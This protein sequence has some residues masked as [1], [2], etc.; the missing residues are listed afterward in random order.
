MKVASFLSKIFVWKINNS[1]S[2]NVEIRFMVFNATFNNIS[3]IL[4]LSVLLVEE[5]GVPE[6]K[7]HRPTVSHWQ[8]LSHNVTCISSTP[9][10]SGIQTHNVS[11]DRQWLIIDLRIIQ[12][13]LAVLKVK[14]TDKHIFVIQFSFSDCSNL[15]D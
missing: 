7:K 14:Q 3:V 15:E 6:R 12:S 5:T 8:T 1:S 4:W 11:G 2:V 13:K 10:L 9:R